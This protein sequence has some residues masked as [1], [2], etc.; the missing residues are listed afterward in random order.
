M[1][2]LIALSYANTHWL[3]PRYLIRKRY[4][5]Y[6]TWLIILMISYTAI[7]SM[8]DFYLFGYVMGALQNPGL[9]RALLFNMLNTV[10]YLTLS[11]TLKLSIDWYEQ[12]RM[13]HQ[14]KIEKLQAE[15]NY[16]RAQ[17]NPH[18]LFNV[19]N[20][21]YSLTMKKSD[22]AP[23]VVLKLSDMMEYMLYES[24]D[25]F[26]PLEKEL[27]YLENYLELERMRLGNR[28]EILLKIEGAADGQRIAPFMLLPLVE[29]A[30]KHG[31]SKIVSKAWLHIHI[32]IKSKELSFTIENGR[33]NFRDD[34][35][36]KGIGL[37]NLKQRL[38]LLYH[39]KH[40]LEIIENDERF[41]LILNINLL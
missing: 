4:A 11:V 25:T 40:T 1:A 20:S 27:G 2:L 22:A 7:Q 37:S 26:V 41:K 31:V 28:A 36:H 24:E 29:N 34:K 33:L 8:Y 23:E 21:L 30:F 5:A 17:V 19:L 12:S 16:L 35:K 6:F 32:N 18:F 13:L 3:M 9:L 38:E 10:W 15:V 39:A 14:I